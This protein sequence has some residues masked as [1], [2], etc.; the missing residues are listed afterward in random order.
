MYKSQCHLCTYPSYC[1]HKN[2]NIIVLSGRCVGMHQ[3]VKPCC[4][5]IFANIQVR[6]L[7]VVP[8]VNTELVTTIHCDGIPC[9]TLDSDRTAVLTVITQQ[10]RVTHTR[11]TCVVSTQ[12]CKDYL[13]AHSVRSEQSARKVSCSMCLII[14]MASFPQHHQKVVTVF[15]SLVLIK[16]RTVI[17][18]FW[19]HR[20]YFQLTVWY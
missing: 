19:G 13:A 10:S 16:E 14:R 1:W 3:L 6:S 4:R 8:C 2:K 7:M 12:A 18:L 15:V 11:I 20:R 9:G 5:C 17:F